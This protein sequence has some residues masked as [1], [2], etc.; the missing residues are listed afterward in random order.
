[1][2]ARTDFEILA[3]S[4]GYAIYAVSIYW[5]RPTQVRLTRGLINPRPLAS[6]AIAIAWLTEQYSLSPEGWKRRADQSLC[7]GKGDALPSA[8]VEEK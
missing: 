4:G 2:G 8:K 5:Q 1:L 3:V 7:Q 6:E